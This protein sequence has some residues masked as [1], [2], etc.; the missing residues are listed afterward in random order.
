MAHRNLPLS[1]SYKYLEIQTYSAV[2]YCRVST[3][4][5]QP[6]QIITTHS[7]TAYLRKGLQVGV[8]C[9]GGYY[10]TDNSRMKNITCL[11]DNNWTSIVS[12]VGASFISIVE[13]QIAFSYSHTKLNFYYIYLTFYFYCKF[14]TNFLNI[15]LSNLSELIYF[16]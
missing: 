12:C 10:Y 16:C 13:Y 5:L 1:L 7:P 4:K 2:D 6:Y 8:V 11:G 9:S 15:F 14:F 3:A